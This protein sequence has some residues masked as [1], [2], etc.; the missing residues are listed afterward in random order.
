MGH[1][2]RHAEGGPMPFDPHD[3]VQ[4]ERYSRQL[5]LRPIGARGQRA[6]G[7]ARV[8]VVGAGGLGAPA[9]LYLAAAGVGA[10]TVADGDVVD[11]SNLNRQV[12]FA[13]ADLGR[14]KAEAAAGKLRALNSQL[15]VQAHPAVTV[16]N[17]AALVA[18]HDLVLDASDNFPTRFLLADACRLGGKPL[19]HAGVVGFSGQLT[20]FLPDRGPCYRC[21][22]P[23]PPA[24]GAVPNCDEA[25]VLGAA[26]GVLGAMQAVEAIKVLV[27]APETTLSGRLLL[28]DLWAGSFESVA[29]PRDPACPLCG[30]QPVITALLPSYDR[31]EHTRL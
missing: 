23:E 28:V 2:A 4:L 11:R 7:Q 10:I 27:G 3:P 8:L 14:S 21:F 30:D 6:L 31:P 24:S 1:P 13:E 17:A 22:F 16:G 20:T 25:G 12:L 15:D 9:L 5:M 29:L 26:A 18:A 19:V